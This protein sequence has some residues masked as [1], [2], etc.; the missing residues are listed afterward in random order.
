M[1]M[2]TLNDMGEKRINESFRQYNLTL[3]QT[4][5]LSALYL[6]DTGEYTFKELE[7]LFHVSQQT[8]A[9][10]I[11]RL[12]EKGFVTSYQDANDRRI[13][14]AA[15]T[16]KGLRLKPDIQEKIAE[17]EEWFTGILDEDEI[18]TLI[19]FLDRIYDSIK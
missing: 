10:L 5:V 1:K 19:T 12:E 14:R 17:N 16:E 7:G 11:G 13:K 3:S 2:K 4:R 18:T 8:M 15:L 6:S 9:G